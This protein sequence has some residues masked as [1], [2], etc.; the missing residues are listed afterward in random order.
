MIMENACYGFEELMV[1]SMV[2]AGLFGDLLHGECAY[3]HDLRGEIFGDKGEGLWRRAPHTMRNGN[4]YP[5]HGLGP[6]SNYM[7][8]N[9]GDCFDYLVSM[10][11]P[12]KGFD[13]YRA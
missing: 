13:A 12:Q 8:I 7:G 11:S 9:R 5:T 3:I 1:L 6:I 10:S 4:L 2:R